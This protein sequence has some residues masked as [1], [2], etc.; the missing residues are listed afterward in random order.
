MFLG[1]YSFSYLVVDNYDFIFLFG[2]EEGKNGKNQ[3]ENGK[4]AP[5]FSAKCKKAPKNYMIED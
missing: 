4:I 1:D 2:R 5:T 3:R